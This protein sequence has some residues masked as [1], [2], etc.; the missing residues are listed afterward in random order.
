[1]YMRIRTCRGWHPVVGMLGC[2]NAE[3]GGGWGLH[4]SLT[5]VI[6]IMQDPWTLTPTSYEIPRYRNATE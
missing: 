3:R 1:M 2:L 4:L 5:I 6:G